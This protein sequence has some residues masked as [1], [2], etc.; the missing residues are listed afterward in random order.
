MKKIK[1]IIGLIL[2]MGAV[3]VAVIFGPAE[4]ISTIRIFYGSEKKGL[5]NDPYFKE[6]LRKKFNISIEGTSMGSL[7]M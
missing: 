4:K 2:I 6:I 5:L 1:L 3:T 7:E